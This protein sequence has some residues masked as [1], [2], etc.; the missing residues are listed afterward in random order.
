MQ[1]GGQELT[2]TLNTTSVKTQQAPQ[3]A[4]AAPQAAAKIRCPKCG[5]LVDA[6]TKFCPQC[7][8]SLTQPRKF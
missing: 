5:A 7:G 4:P 1:S 2:A 3:P 6:G 8:T